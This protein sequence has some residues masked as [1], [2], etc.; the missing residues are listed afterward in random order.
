MDVVDDVVDDVVEDAVGTES[1]L[2]MG[3]TRGMAAVEEEKDE[4]GGEEEEETEGRVD[5]MTAD[6]VECA[7]VA[8]VAGNFL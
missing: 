3:G 2:T 1:S 8:V 7:F 6:V 4:E 5:A